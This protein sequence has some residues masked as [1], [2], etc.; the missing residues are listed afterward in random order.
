MK[1]KKLILRACLAAFA[2]TIILY[3]C[4]K[5]NNSS[6]DEETSASL[7]ASAVTSESLYSDV[8]DV[9]VQTS[10]ENGLN[11]TASP[12]A[13]GE[14]PGGANGMDSISSCAQV[15]ISPSDTSYPKTVTIDFGTGCT[16]TT[17]I[18]R[19]GKLTAVITGK[20]W[21]SGTTVTVTFDNY[22]VNGYQLE[23]T[24]SITN[25]S[26]GANG[27]QCTT[28]VKDGKVTYP[29]GRYYSFSETETIAQTEGMNTPALSDNVYN[30]TGGY[31]CSS[32]A[33]N[34]VVAT[35]T[36]ALVKTATCKNIVEG[37]VQLVYNNIP[38]TLDFGSGSC[39]NQ[40]TLK[41][42][43]KTYDVTLPR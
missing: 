43:T 26:S 36:S 17:G 20:L 35:I 19:K 9:V 2:A 4:K 15:T 38:G 6:S 40:A 21:Q 34:T 13:G 22:S 18:T 11:N 24:Y 37:T 33:G 12:D 32:S 27:F 3:A 7:S 39:D 10:D 1:R 28:T 42:G 14:I 16:S 31:T 29:D 30:I 8:F 25:N 41:V 5:D 23:G